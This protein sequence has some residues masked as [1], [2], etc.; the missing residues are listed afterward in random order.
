MALSPRSSRA[1][2]RW[3]GDKAD[4][5]RAIRMSRG[6][7]RPSIRV[8]LARRLRHRRANIRR[9]GTFF[10]ALAFEQCRAAMPAGARDKRRRLAVGIAA[11]PIAREIDDVA[12]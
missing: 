11:R 8:K 5:P 6:T 1:W 2:R 4:Q 3:P 10:L 7:L 12:G 9:A